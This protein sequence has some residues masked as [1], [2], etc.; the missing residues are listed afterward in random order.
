MDCAEL[1]EELS[2]YV[3]H[4]LDPDDRA[5]IEAHLASCEWC[6]EE[7]ASYRTIKAL[8]SR[9]KLEEEDAPE[10]LQAFPDVIGVVAAPTA[11]HV[12]WLHRPVRAR[13]IVL[14]AAAVLVG[15]LLGWREYEARYVYGALQREAVVTHLHGVA[16]ALPAE[17]SQAM[18]VSL[19]PIDDQ[20]YA[21]FEGLVSVGHLAAFQTVYFMGS[22]PISQL[23]FPAGD[24]DDSRF[25]ARPVGGR[26]YRVGRVGDY[27]IAS[28]RRGPAQIVLV[29]DVAPEA[30]LVLAQN[31][32]PDTPFSVGGTGY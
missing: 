13:S 8:V 7:V 27:A 19:R 28:Y 29:S 16:A 23:R 20:V 12:S 32:P 3:D 10:T 30:L 26:D 5:R 11:P 14:A 21:R 18:N 6:S 15:L 9:S 1:Q 24:F 22:H 17:P 31:I 25:E 2:A 4:E